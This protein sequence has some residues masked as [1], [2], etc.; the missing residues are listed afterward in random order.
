MATMKRRK[1]LILGA[2]GR[3]GAAL[4][5]ECARDHDVLA[6]GRSEV[7]LAAPEK[8]A[9]SIR[10]AAPDVVINCAA[11]TNVDICEVDREMAETVNSRAPSAIARACAEIGAKMIQVSTDYVFSGRKTEPYCESDPADPISWYGETKKR[12]ETGVLEASGNHAVVR[13]AWVFGPDRECFIDQ[14]LKLALRGEPV[15][16][17][18]DK[19]SSPTYTLDAAA[20]LL[21]LVGPSAPG[22]IYHLCNSGVCSWRDWAQQTI[23]AAVKLG[24]P[25]RTK[26]VE[27]IRLS[28]IKAMVAARPVYSAMSCE[29]LEALLGSPLRPWQKAVGAYVGL[30]KDTGRL[31]G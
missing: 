5:R 22:G 20:A 29:R 7:D 21:A 14:A 19:L 9:L 31:A 3:L 27:P 13:V 8:A 4:A 10:A 24:L 12:G 2:R 15:R 11:A 17:V 18:A 23:D 16:A 30:L 28:D 26:V 6:C 25:V 1:L